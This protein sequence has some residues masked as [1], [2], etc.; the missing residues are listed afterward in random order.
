MT[1]VRELIQYLEK[2]PPDTE[3]SVIVGYDC[4][5]SYCTEEVALNL[6]P[7]K[8]NIDFLDF[9]NNQFVKET[10]ELYNKTFLTLGEK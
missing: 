8:G 3:V 6:D 10:H 9:R 4:G 7:Y 2:L 5:Y 1:T